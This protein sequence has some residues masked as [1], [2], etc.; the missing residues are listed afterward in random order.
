MFQVDQFVPGL[1]FL[2]LYLALWAARGENNRWATLWNRGM[3]GAEWVGSLIDIVGFL[4]IAL[5]IGLLMY[6][7]IA[8]EWK[9]TIGLFVLGLIAPICF[10]L[11]GPFVAAASCLTLYNTQNIN[12]SLFVALVGGIGATVVVL[13]IVK[14]SKN[15]RETYL[16]LNYI[17][18]TFLVIPLGLFIILLTIFDAEFV[19]R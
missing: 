9:I 15:V 1:E 10:A 18:G 14:Y 5:N 3:R 2:S 12:F 16:Y 4:G 17:L 19:R 7:G 8:I 13:P 11:T 6:V